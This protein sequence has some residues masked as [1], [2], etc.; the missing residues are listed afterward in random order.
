M[1]ETDAA[2]LARATDLLAGV[3]T[4]TTGP[5]DV[6][7]DDARTS[8]GLH[9][10]AAVAHLCLGTHRPEPVLDAQPIELA[11]TG[12]AVEAALRDALH[13]LVQLSPAIFD[14]D[15]VLDAVTEIHAALAATG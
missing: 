3:I 11:A 7:D 8:T 1:T 5:T 12:L 6:D 10:M 9:A 4:A 15:P 14:T 13:Q 2:L